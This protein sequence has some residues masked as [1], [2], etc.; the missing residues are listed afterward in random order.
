[1]TDPSDGDDYKP[2]PTRPQHRPSILNDEIHDAI[3]Q[4]SQAGATAG[5]AAEHAGVSDR[6]IRLWMQK[7]AQAEWDLDENGIEPEGD[8]VKYL[9]LYRDVTKARASRAV[10]D[11]ALIHRSAEGGQIIEETVKKYRDPDTGQV[12]E[13]RTIKRSPGD[14]RAASWYLSKQ[15]RNHGFG[16]EETVAL[17]GPD[18]GP[19][20]LEGNVGDLAARLATTLAARAAAKQIEGPPPD[21]AETVEGEVVS[22]S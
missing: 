15:A 10:K 5:M 3:V 21:D 9:E 6:V 7:G 12:V 8:D 16:N 17:T 20:Q 19:V 13:E 4:A 2:P 11:V 1:M 14:W 22:D 18:G